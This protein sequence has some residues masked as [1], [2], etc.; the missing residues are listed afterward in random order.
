M[1]IHL[2]LGVSGI[3]ALMAADRAAAGRDR[4]DREWDDDRCSGGQGVS[5][6]WG[7][8]REIPDRVE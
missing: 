7:D 2:S 4:C 3:V 6:G 8:L 5:S 1:E